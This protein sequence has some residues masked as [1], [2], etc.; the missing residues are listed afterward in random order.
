MLLMIDNYDSFTFNLVQYFQKLDQEVLVKRNDEVSL[1]QIKQLNPHHIVISPGPCSP[2]E[3]GISLQVVEQLQGRFPILGVCL[4]HQTIAQVLGAK[5]ER[6]KQVM[7]G[8][9]SKLHHNNKGVFEGLPSSFNVCRYH[10]LA[11]D[12]ST[13]PPELVLTAWT[14]SAS[15]ELDEV[16]G[17]CHTERALEGVQFHPEAILTEYGLRL[18]DNFIARF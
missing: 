13:L 17:L 16:M 15:G 10:S 18:L 3:A 7:H 1:A 6:A 12:I 4:G 11:V 2:N 14:Q 8:K 5:V 9:V